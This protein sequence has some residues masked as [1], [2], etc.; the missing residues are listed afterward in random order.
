MKTNILNNITK[1]AAVVALAVTTLTA[2]NVSAQNATYDQTQAHL[3]LYFQQFGG[4]QTVMVNLGPAWSYRDA[5]A[6]IMNI[7][8]LGGTLT[9]STGSGGAGYSATWYDDTRI[10]T[11]GDPL[12][13]LSLTYWGVAA[14]RTSTDSN[15]AAV[16]GDP[17]RTIYVSRDHINT[18]PDGTAGSTPWSIA[19]NSTMTFGAN[20]II[21]QTI[22]M[23]TVATSTIFVEPSSASNVDNQNPTT[24]DNL[25]TAFTA[26]PGGV[27]GA[28]GAGNYGTIGG[29]AA[30]GAIDLYRIL[31]STTAS[32]IVENGT[33]R[34]GQYQGTFVIDQAGS[35][36]YIAP[37]PEPATIGLL[38][39]SAIF[40]LARR[41][42]ARR[43]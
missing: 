34:Q 41:R 33:L 35:V 32:G 43:G 27:M 5:T 40:G 42:R 31:A 7:E 12:P 1:K 30:E 6:N 23:E 9:G 37:I 20:G 4:T 29:V 26:F 16:D 13:V 28:F 38:A 19:T 39:S 22:R 2:S 10:G 24:G 11:I 21:G 25:S 14:V 17:H 15:A 36:S 18:V 3:L 8:N